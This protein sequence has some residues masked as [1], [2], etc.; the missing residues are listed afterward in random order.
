MSKKI[1]ILCPHPENVAPGQRL[2]YEQYFSHWKENGYEITV[3]SFMTLRFWNVVYKK[4]FLIEKVGWTI[5]GYLRRC[6][7]LFQ[8]P[9]YDVTYVFLW[10]TPFGKSFYEKIIRLLSKRLIYDIDDMVFLGHSSDANRFW[11]VLKGKDK[12]IYLMKSANHVI[13]CTP[14][15]DEFVEQFNLNTTD[16]SS[17]VD[18]TNKYIPVNPYKNNH[19][20]VLGWSGSHSTSKYLYLLQDVFIELAKKFDYKLLVMGDASFSIEGVHVEAYDWSENIE[21]STLQKIDIGLYPL[22]DEEWVYGKSGL[23]AIQYMALGIPTIATG[24]GAN[25]RVIEHEKNGFLIKP[26][27]YNDWKEKIEKLINS[28]TLRKELGIAARKSIVE[29]FSLEANQ[30]KYLKVLQGN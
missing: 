7:N 8:I 27:D 17:T 9:F 2:K 5:F 25:F 6:F 30:G 26:N 15:L 13:T 11:Q 19:Q 23:K 14:K 18:T 10:G 20:I 29:Q 22:P 4:G 21:I 28:E 16:I 1:L 3:S 12:M 24:L